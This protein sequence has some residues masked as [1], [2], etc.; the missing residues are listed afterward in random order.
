M[1]KNLRPE[2]VLSSINYKYLQ[3]RRE[4][5]L[6]S[7][8][9]VMRQNI[10]FSLDKKLILLV[11]T[12]S[13]IAIVA[14]AAL[15]LNLIDGILK[16]RINDQ[17]IEESTTR[18]NTIKLLLDNRIREVFI[19]S[20]VPLIKNT[21]SQLNQ[22]S[23]DPIL[24]SKIAEKK[25]LIFTEIKNFQTREGHQIELVDVAF[26]GK[27]LKKYFTLENG[28]EFPSK[29][30]I[31]QIASRHLME[32]MQN[33]QGTRQLIVAIPIKDEQNQDV[34]GIIAAVM[35]TNNLDAIL[36]NREG[37]QNTGEAYMV[38]QD[39]LMISKSIFVQNAEFNQ[40]IQTLPVSACFDDHKSITGIVYKNYKNQDIFGTS[41]CQSGYGYVVLTEIDE[42]EILIP[43]FDLQAKIITVSII[44]MLG[45]SSTAYLLS[46]RLSKPIRKLIDAV[47]EIS[48]GNFDVKT[49]IKTSDEI[50]DL[51]D[52][53][54]FMAKKLRES[55][56][57]L[58]KQK[59]IINQQENI[60]LQF[61]DHTENACVCFIDIE[62]S[63][64]ICAKLSESEASSL[65]S[66]FLN[67]MA[68]IIKRYNGIVVKNIGDAL[69]FYFKIDNI[70]DE[71]EFRNV[72]ECCTK[73]RE[74]HDELCIL[75]KKKNLPCV[76]YRT[77]STFGTV[78]IANVSTSEVND[79]FGSTVNLC[80]K[81]NSFAP[82]NGLVIG[83]R[84]YE[85]AKKI[86]GFEFV[87]ISDFQ[88]S[89]NQDLK[90]F[91]VTRT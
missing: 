79:V 40:K 33:S 52:S 84:F 88:I 24:D 54:D 76:N 26:F 14:T 3:H 81:I 58:T 73:L 74:H 30:R 60:L 66:K 38:N 21:I 47:H 65:Y 89:E 53:F 37:L 87:N 13:L 11:L 25:T 83:E 56:I 31:A 63:T 71:N 8:L 70:Q 34:I 5:S 15:S 36:Q 28:T 57:A 1:L 6:E 80:S 86:T 61:S 10:S 51:S 59:E 27:N 46:K 41:H 67:S 82:S 20:S 69:L 48:K 44:I 50:G 29:E 32:F 4:F 78:S 91:S 7:N 23:D 16:E 43:L 12:V 45:I 55:E 64:K 75:L 68:I 22:Y 17:L 42:G 49:N 2:F 19:L 18:G 35:R 90:I 62:N 85:K 72:L 39:R 77:S 9:N